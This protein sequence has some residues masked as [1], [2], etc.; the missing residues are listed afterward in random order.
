MSGL[1]SSHG[2]GGQD[3]AAYTQAA[4]SDNRLLRSSLLSFSSPAAE[5][6]HLDHLERW[7]RFSAGHSADVFDRL[8]FAQMGFQT[9]IYAK[10]LRHREQVPPELLR[11]FEQKLWHFVPGLELLRAAHGHGNSTKRLWNGPR[12]QMRKAL[13]HVHQADFGPRRRRGMV[14]VA[15]NEHL[16][17]AVQLI[18]TIRDAHQSD[19]EIEVYYSG[20]QD[21][22][23]EGRQ[24]L[25]QRF[26]KVKVISLS[27]LNFFD[28]Q[29]VG[30]RDSGW[31]MRSYALLASNFTEAMLVDA[32]A[33]LL[34]NP[35]DFFIEKGYQRTGTLFFRDLL[36]RESKDEK[37]KSFLHEQFGQRGPSKSL[38]NGLFWKEGLS[39]HQDAGV[40]V[41]NKAN[42]D[43]FAGLLFTI[44]QN[45]AFTRTD[46]TYEHFAGDKESF[47][48]SHEL[49][50][51]PYHFTPYWAGGLGA[52]QSVHSDGF[53]ADHQLH[54]FDANFTRPQRKSDKLA[55]G[56]RSSKGR[57]AWF[58]GSTL[59]SKR[60]GR[61]GDLLEAHNT[62]WAPNGEWKR[63]G[64]STCLVNY[65]RYNAQEL[66][67]EP[68]LQTVLQVARDA[69]ERMANVLD[70]ED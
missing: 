53:C 30:I 2:S 61:R 15:G 67:V 48:L 11:L 28:E 60:H 12:V 36:L 3:K 42:P 24:Y 57:I 4:E 38:A 68:A 29:F 49:A 26:T 20:E 17:D 58:N 1:F 35:D 22:S 47:W 40:V 65:S 46:V 66:G 59:K 32:D 64:S 37:V 63:R 52:E 41:V 44:W 43:V 69:Y 55:N 56:E 5:L 21:L 31:A 54:I 9:S 13:S 70:H 19:I 50:G 6:G 33:I 51:L 34:G 23:K 7:L 25:E 18:A 14:I 16:R 39:H 27:D 10:L 45:S 62:V 8:S